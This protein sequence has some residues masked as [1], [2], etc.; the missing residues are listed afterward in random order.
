V[1]WWPGSASIV[2]VIVRLLLAI[3]ML[4]AA[5]RRGNLVR[6][7]RRRACAGGAQKAE[8]PAAGRRAARIA[9]ELHDSVTHHVTAM[10]VQ[11][12]ATQFLIDTAAERAK[13]G[14]LQ[15][16]CYTKLRASTSCHEL[17][18]HERSR[19]HVQTHRAW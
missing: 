6:M 14:D 13:D 5:H 12:D 18:P 11:T 3:P 1:A 16:A 4:I 2:P 8:P 17:M 10:V 9:G 7:R 19:D 15:P